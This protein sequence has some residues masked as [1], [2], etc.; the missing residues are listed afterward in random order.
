MQAKG[1]TREQ[2]QSE[3]AQSLIEGGY[4]NSPSVTVEMLWNSRPSISSAK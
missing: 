1:K 3:I 2:L 4:Y